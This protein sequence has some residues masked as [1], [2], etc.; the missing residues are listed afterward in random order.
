M[1]SWSLSAP[2]PPLMEE[3]KYFTSFAEQLQRRLEGETLKE[4]GKWV[5]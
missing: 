3:F 4:M 1:L 2:V 5:H